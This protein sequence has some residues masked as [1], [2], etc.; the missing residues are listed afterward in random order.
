MNSEGL[1]KYNDYFYILRDKAL[2]EEFIK[3]YYNNSL[4]GYFGA[5]KSYKLFTRKFF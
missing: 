4:I 5:I 1:L 2:K 3:R